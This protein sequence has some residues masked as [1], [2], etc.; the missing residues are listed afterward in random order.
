MKDWNR[1]HELEVQIA[2]DELRFHEIERLEEA[3]MQNIS[4]Q[5]F[6]TASTEGRYRGEKE[7]LSSSILRN[8]EMLAGV[9][10]QPD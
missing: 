5:G 2:Q 1:I 10:T 7:A 8:R 4:H 3:L 9:K 6:S